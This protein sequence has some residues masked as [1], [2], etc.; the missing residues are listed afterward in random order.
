MR[1]ADVII[2]GSGIAS[3]QL[4]KSLN[5]EFHVIIITKSNKESSNSSMAQGGIAAA[6]SPNDHVMKHYK[7]TLAAGRW[8]H[9][10]VEVQ[11]LV[12]EGKSIV[13][14][15]NQQKF[16]F[17]RKVNGDLSMGMEGAHSAE[18][19]VHS[20]GD[21]TGKFLIQH[22][23]KTLP[24]N[25]EIIEHEAVISLLQEE[26]TNRCI[27]VL[28]C[29]NEQELA[30]Y[31]APHIVLATGGAGRFYSFTS[32]HHNSTGDGL[33]M[34]YL[35]GA[36]LTDL[37]F[38]QFHPTLLFVSG[39][40]KGLVSEAVRGEGAFL[41]NQFGQ[42]IMKHQHVLKDLAPRHIVAHEIFKER[43]IGN[44]VF[45]DISPIANFQEKFPTISTLCTEHGVC[46]QKG[47]IPVA[48]GSHFLMGGIMVNSVG[49]SSIKGLYAIGEVACTGVHGANRLA[50]NSLLEGLV[51]GERLANYLNEQQKKTSLTSSIE[52]PSHS[53]F[54]TM[55]FDS[56]E[57]RLK[58]MKNVGVIRD[59]GSLRKHLDWLNEQQK[60]N[61]AIHL[62]A[63]HRLEG[64]Q[65]YF[66][67]L[68]GKL[69]TESALLRTESRGGHIRNDFPEEKES[70]CQKRIVHFMKDGEM[71]VTFNEQLKIKNHA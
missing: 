32:N 29:N 9:D 26:E 50:S 3:L 33:A 8:H 30:A 57:F 24:D 61:Q 49:E 37:E 71:K 68:I 2:I 22:L 56:E 70:W 7:D 65:R 21:A 59:T 60:M 45:L 31:Y 67:W 35:A 52:P 14:S 41:V 58:M 55:N 54:M 38:F 64:I 36:H 20:G 44:E 19:I 46:L 39:E 10:E 28:T 48:P 53:K 23:V 34:A 6:L 69:M 27:G 66:M 43:A 47:K 1:K 40:T 42:K 51:Y 63:G 62:I 16:P 17:D 13:Q 18:R 12:E 25:I 11:R 4:A 5:H 15:L